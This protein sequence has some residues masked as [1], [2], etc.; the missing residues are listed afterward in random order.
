VALLHI[1][2]VDIKSVHEN[3]SAPGQTDD[4][5]GQEKKKI[6]T[7]P[8]QSAWIGIEYQISSFVYDHLLIS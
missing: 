2:V 4:S 6:P 5:P 8:T 1:G 7:L 3:P